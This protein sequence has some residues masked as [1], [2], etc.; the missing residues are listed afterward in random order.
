[1]IKPMVRGSAVRLASA[2]ALLIIISVDTLAAQIAPVA[3]YDRNDRA[4]EWRLAPSP[5]LT[6]EGVGDVPFSR[7]SGAVRLD[8]GRIV[9]ADR[10]TRQIH[11]F[12]ADGAW[13]RTVGRRGKGPG[14]FTDIDDLQ[15]S[16]EMLVVFDGNLAVHFIRAADGRY[17]E[18]QRLPRVSGYHT[19]PAAGVFSSGTIVHRGRPIRPPTPAGVMVEDSISL[20]LVPA[21]SSPRYLKSYPT[22]RMIQGAKQSGS[23]PIGFGPRETF[24]FFA[25][26][27]CSGYTQRYEIACFTSSG[28]PLVTIRRETS[29][30]SVT[31]RER[32][33]LRRSMAGFGNDGSNR[34]EGSL[35]AH[36]E[37][38]AA[39]MVFSE[40]H[41][42]F[43]G[44]FAAR[45]GD[46]WVR[47]YAPEDGAR[48]GNRV[49]PVNASVWNI[50]S[51]TGR[52]IGT[53]RLVA[54][55]L[56]TDIGQDYALG[57]LKDENDVET[58][59]LYRLMR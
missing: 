3:L 58:V 30:R 34:Y 56:P 23:A 22:G 20:F 7:I 43:S 49:F 10:D 59:A 21:N 50:F 5:T 42:A 36:R 55:F 31:T 52:W 47:E 11:Y 14:E 39:N 46:L 33:A 45:T 8:D 13:L 12:G 54:S 15:L 26:R 44:L 18:T 27:F 53:V 4:P 40:T 17:I 37:K 19:N 32:A 35:R 9:I 41:P 2:A 6:H 38:V 25:D 1:M 28:A 24:A 29:K 51:P 57:V 48:A 16:G